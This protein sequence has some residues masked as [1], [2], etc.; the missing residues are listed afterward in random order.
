MAGVVEDMK[1]VLEWRLRDGLST[2]GYNEAKAFL[3]Q[4]GQEVTKRAQAADR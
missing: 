1:A 3:N 2:A 4:L